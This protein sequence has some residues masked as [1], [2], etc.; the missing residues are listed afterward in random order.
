MMENNERHNSKIPSPIHTSDFWRAKISVVSLYLFLALLYL[1]FMF[2]IERS[3]FSPFTI[4]SILLS[5]V[6]GCRMVVFPFNIDK[7]KVEVS[8]PKIYQRILKLKFKKRVFFLFIALFYMYLVNTIV[9]PLLAGNP[10]KFYDFNFLITCIPTILIVLLT[11]NKDSRV[12]LNTEGTD[13]NEK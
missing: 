6:I 8:D 12:T 1:S 5:I 10:L 2:D 9:A 4:G 3:F 13:D 7:V 11:A